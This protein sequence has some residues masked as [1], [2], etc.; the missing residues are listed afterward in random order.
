MT[1]RSLSQVGESRD[2]KTPSNLGQKGME[3]GQEAGVSSQA[4]IKEI[5]VK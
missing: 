1:C 2:E 5:F 3:Q 4:F